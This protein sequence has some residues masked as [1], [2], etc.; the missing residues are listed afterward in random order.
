MEFISFQEEFLSEAEMIKIKAPDLKVKEVS[1]FSLFD[2]ISVDSWLIV[3]FGQRFQLLTHI[4]Y[5][6]TDFV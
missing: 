3:W 5:G 2:I 1:K 6:N 4:N